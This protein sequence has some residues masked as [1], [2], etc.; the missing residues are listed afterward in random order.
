MQGPAARADAA[1]K[2]RASV[3]NA[4]RGLGPIE[5]PVLSSVRPALDEFFD[6]VAGWEAT[7]SP[8][9]REAMKATAAELVSQWRSAT[10]SR[11]SRPEVHARGGGP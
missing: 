10:A 9:D 8:D 7:G 3:Q 1:R 4:V 11:N 5:A 2:V 6:A